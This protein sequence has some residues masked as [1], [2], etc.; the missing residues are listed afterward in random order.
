MSMPS[1]SERLARL[2]QLVFK[3]AA[4]LTTL[5]LP[6][7]HTGPE[8][9]TDNALALAWLC[10]LTYE[11]DPETRQSTLNRAGMEEIAHHS[12]QNL[13]WSRLRS[14]TAPDHHVLAFRGTADLQHWFFNLNTLLTSWPGGG[15]VH[16]G[17]ASAY[18]RLAKSL[19][20]DLSC[21]PPKHLWITGHSLGGAF[22]LFAANEHPNESVYT[23]GCPRAGSPRFAEACEAASRIHRVVHNQDIVTTIPYEISF[24]K[25][26]AYKHVG[27]VT[28]LRQDCPIAVEDETHLPHSRKFWREAVHAMIEGDH[29]GEPLP[30]LLDHAPSLYVSRIL[31]AASL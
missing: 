3:P 30:A 17:F 13:H 29:V 18:K 1:E 22:A 8:F 15:K 26:I 20:D 4:H 16:G 11:K 14:L 2:W 28:H 21:T 27:S 9:H 23:F 10:Q 12:T 5:E 25:E 24:L 19:T 6:T 31:E 7:L